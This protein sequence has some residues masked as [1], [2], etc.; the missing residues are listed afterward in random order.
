V[1]ALSAFNDPATVNSMFAAGA[2]AYIAKEAPIEEMLEAIRS[3]AAL[4][5]AAGAR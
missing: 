4:A 2:V 1:V 3:A 5:E